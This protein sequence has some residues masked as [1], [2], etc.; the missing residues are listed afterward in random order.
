MG[1]V[2]LKAYLTTLW[3]GMISDHCVEKFLLFV[4]SNTN[5]RISRPSPLPDDPGET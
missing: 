3:L 4:L 1:P 2:L 5:N